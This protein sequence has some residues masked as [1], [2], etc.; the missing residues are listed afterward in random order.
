MK[1]IS[2]AINRLYLQ[3]SFLETDQKQRIKVK[4]I[5]C[6]ISKKRKVIAFTNDGEFRI[7]E[8]INE[9]E[10]RFQGLFL[11]SHRHYLVN[12][13]Y[14]EG[15]SRRFNVETSAVRGVFDEGMI[16]LRGFDSGVPIT[17]TYSRAIKKALRI[18]SFHYLLPEHPEDKRLR[19]LGLINFGWRELM[20]LNVKN[21]K[22]VEAFKQKWDIKR[23]D[24]HRMLDYFRRIE[25]PEID[26]R[27]VF[28]NLIFQKHQ[29]I[30][31]GIETKIDGNIRSFWYEIKRTLAH[32]F[33]IWKPSDINIF[34]DSLQDMIEEDRLFRYKDFGFM[35]M[36]EAYREIGDGRPEV[37][38]VVEKRGLYR[39]IRQIAKE[40]GATFVSL[41]GEP[42]ILS[43]E[44][45]SDE[46]RPAVGAKSLQVISITDL[47]PAGYSIQRNLVAGLKKQGLR[48]GQVVRVVSPEIFSS[49]ED[50]EWFRFPVVRYK[51]VKKKI[52][53]VES[54][55]MSQITK[56]RA[57][58][59]KINDKRFMTEKKIEGGKLVTIWGIESD[60]AERSEIRRI[61]GEALGSKIVY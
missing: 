40:I 52:I 37:I 50:V 1:R 31:A 35:D 9:L 34:Y 7:L 55:N 45:F 46:L 44:Y 10:E 8:V 26:K 20:Q 11:R 22:L 25:K 24:K 48:V 41:R 21:K 60:S 14:I 6:F 49:D 30:K 29:W 54:T 58:F 42:S 61:V 56:A 57:W 13:D 59:K 4:D 36:G 32:D 2:E 53:P 19:L 12:L 51:V 5:I 47:D 28:R 38:L 3:E 16:Y 17:E 33:D 23:F 43:M 39:F 27:M 18:R 15:F